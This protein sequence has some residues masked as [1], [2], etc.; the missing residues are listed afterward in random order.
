MLNMTKDN[1]IIPFPKKFKRKPS[2]KDMEVQKRIAQEHQK[3][4]CQAMCD[5]ITENILIKLHSENLNVT[6]KSFLVDYKIVSEAIRSMLF[7][8]QGLKHDLQKRADKSVT[9]KKDK[10]NNPYAITI[11]YDKF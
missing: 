7:R 6:N 11:D 9:Y 5:E 4:F 1:N 3:I 2:E 10:H 8:T